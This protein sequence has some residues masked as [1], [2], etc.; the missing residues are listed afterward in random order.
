MEDNLVKLL[1]D[2][3]I[4]ANTELGK[5]KRELQIL[6]EENRLYRSQLEL[7]EN[8]PFLKIY[9]KPLKQNQL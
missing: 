8:T 6:T 9:S 7:K 2:R 4:E 3:L 5:T 1:I